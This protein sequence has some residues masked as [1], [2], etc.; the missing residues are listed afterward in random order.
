M[1]SAAPVSLVTWYPR[2]NFL[3][4]EPSPHRNR[5]PA[6][7]SARRP[8]WRRSAECRRCRRSDRRSASGPAGTPAHRS[9]RGV[10]PDVGAIELLVHKVRAF[11]QRGRHHAGRARLLGALGFPANF[12][13]TIAVAPAAPMRRNVSRR[14]SGGSDCLLR[15]RSLLSGSD[16]LR[17]TEAS[18]RSGSLRKFIA[19]S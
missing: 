18:V 6:R 10:R 2:R 11:G 7:R 19:E 1:N 15:H 14:L 12:P 17:S 9:V 8:Q 3:P 4:A 5:G 13:P 16:L